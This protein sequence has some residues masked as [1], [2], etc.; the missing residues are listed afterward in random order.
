MRLK[1]TALTTLHG[2]VFPKSNFKAVTAVLNRTPNIKE[3]VPGIL[4]RTISIRRIHRKGQSH[5]A[6]P[7]APCQVVGTP[8][9]Q[10]GTMSF[11]DSWRATGVRPASHTVLSGSRQVV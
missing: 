1:R 3:W 6:E 5:G 2:Y 8:P 7:K 4:V 9:P 10:P 11:P